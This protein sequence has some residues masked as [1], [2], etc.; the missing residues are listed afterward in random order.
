MKKWQEWTIAIVAIVLV[1]G[2]IGG[3]YWYLTDDAGSEAI[4]TVEATQE[5]KDLADVNADLEG[6]ED[7]DLTALET[8]DKDLQAIDLSSL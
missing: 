7:L 3:V 8:I 2:A 4:V 1:V 5:E 6:I